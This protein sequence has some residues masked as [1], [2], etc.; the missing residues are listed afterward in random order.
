MCFPPENKERTKLMS[1]T[2]QQFHIEDDPEGGSAFAL[3]LAAAGYAVETSFVDGSVLIS[4]DAVD[5]EVDLEKKT[6]QVLIR[7]LRRRLNDQSEEM[8]DAKLGKPLH[9]VA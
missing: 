1:A 5:P 7:R 8:D 4:A 3:F 2:R 6:P 9:N